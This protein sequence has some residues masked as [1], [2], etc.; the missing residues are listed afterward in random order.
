MRKS[1]PYNCLSSICSF[2]NMNYIRDV[3]TQLSSR[4]CLEWKLNCLL[5][6]E[7]SFYLSRCNWVAFR[8][9]NGELFKTAGWW[10][11]WLG[12]CLSTALLHPTAPPL[13]TAPL[14]AA[15]GDSHPFAYYSSCCGPVPP[16][17]PPSAVANRPAPPPTTL[18]AVATATPPSSSG[19]P[20]VAPRV[21]DG[22]LAMDA[23]DHHGLYLFLQPWT[24][25]GRTPIRLG[26]LGGERNNCRVAG[27]GSSKSDSLPA[28]SWTKG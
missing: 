17:T 18:A 15:T 14:A 1:R 16:P 10:I 20:P 25:E 12:F 19:A 11:S 2:S 4:R 21:K 13:S 26:K 8:L 23:M 9:I 24:L 28:S 3:S 6:F 7:S 22:E 27:S 5:H